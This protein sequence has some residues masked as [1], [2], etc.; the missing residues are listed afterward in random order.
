MSLRPDPSA[1]FSIFGRRIST[2]A[3][4]DHSVTDVLPNLPLLQCSAED[5]CKLCD[6]FRRV[7]LDLVHR[8]FELRRALE[9]RA[10]REPSRPAEVPVDLSL[11]IWYFGENPYIRG[12]IK[13][14]SFR[15]GILLRFEEEE[16]GL[17]PSE[18][19]R[20]RSAL[21]SYKIVLTRY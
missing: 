6:F 19:H 14:G 12:G 9:D 2:Y 3:D 10:A 20:P 5:G 4:I 17:G 1:S 11:K 15:K 13:I 7:I 16:T 21:Y 8:D 18:Q